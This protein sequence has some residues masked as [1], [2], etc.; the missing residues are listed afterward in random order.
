MKRDLFMGEFRKLYRM[1]VFYLL[2]V[3]CIGVNIFFIWDSVAHKLDAIDE[4]R[5]WMMEDPK[6]YGDT[7]YF[8]AY[9]ETSFDQIE[10][11]ACRDK[12]FD[13]LA[14]RL[15]SGN[16]DKLEARV[17]TMSVKEKES[18]TF[19]GGYKLHSY[20]FVGLFPLLA[21]EGMLM[22]LLATVYLL[23]FEGYFQTEDLMLTTRTGPRM[24][25]VKLVA[26][27]VFGLILCVLLVCVSLGIWFAL[28]DYS[29]I[30]DSYISSVFNAEKRTINDWYIVFYPFVTWHPMT[31]AGYLKA[32]LG[33]LL[34]LYIMAWVLSGIGALL[35]RQSFLLL[36][37]AGISVM[38]LYAVGNLV[39][40]PGLIDFVLKCNPV[41]LILKGGYW[42]MD[43]AAGDTYQGYEWLV[44]GLWIGVGGVMLWRLLVKMKVGK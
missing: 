22:V 29:A 11:M 44:C 6:G 32:S 10:S 18:L 20:L 1:P 19:T 15:V 37:C 4:E 14:G 33:I 39:Q 17:E 31:I 41:H 40:I 27:G 26:A 23:H 38:G 5:I 9:G 2:L 16:F 43:Y 12:T 28:I 7:W 25:V 3:L 36:A 24:Y 8:D 42:F 13:G 35:I 34:L 30:W 21:A